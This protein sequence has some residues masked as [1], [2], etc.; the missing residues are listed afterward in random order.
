MSM[1]LKSFINLLVLGVVVGLTACSSGGDGGGAPPVPS[2]N[3]AT[4]PA[5]VGADNAQVLGETATEA[6]AEAINADTTSAGSPF[7]VS[8]S[9]ASDLTI[10]N[11]VAEIAKQ[12]ADNA[13]LSN[14]PLA[15]TFSYTELGDPNFCGGSFS[16][17]DSVVNSQTPPSSFTITFN[18]ICYDA[19][20]DGLSQMV[21]NGQ[22]QYSE[23]AS[24]FT[25][26]Y[27][28]FTVTM[29]GRTETL[30]FMMTC[31]NFGG[32]SYS[33]DYVG[34]D[35]NTY[36]LENFSVTGSDSTGYNVSATFYHPDYGSVDITTTTPIL[37]NCAPNPQPGS[38]SLTFMGANGTSGSIEFNSCDSYTYCYGSSGM[39]EVC[40]TGMW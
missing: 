28:N 3:G 18:N 30:N 21:M 26:R 16:V 9:Q 17:P 24:G 29:D 32:C 12:L 40:D 6:T 31:D 20:N 35:G 8:I 2:Y 4:T 39:S 5:T 37:F 7:G 10:E 25:I 22:I 11:K 14:K 36:R 23:T 19:P 34:D 15:A 33:S 38:G 13:K 1:I 27:I